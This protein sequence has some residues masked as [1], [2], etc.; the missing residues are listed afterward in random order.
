MKR[1]IA[2]A[3][4]FVLMLATVA[5][6]ADFSAE[7]LSRSGKGKA[8][9]SKL[10]FTKDKMRTEAMGNI[11]IVRM[12]KNVMWNIMTGQKAYMEMKIPAQS[13]ASMSNKAPGEIKREKLGRETINGFR[14]D[15]YKVTYKDPEGRKTSSMYQWLSGDNIPIKSA[16]LDGSWSS[17][18]KNMKKGAQPGSLFEIPAG[19]K[20]MSIPMGAGMGNMKMMPKNLQKMMR[21]GQ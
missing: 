8:I 11:T 19:Y 5:A 4:L 16:A 13:R 15:K 3:A 7:M 12:D 6:A 14:C 9:A 18:I 10:F 17:E 1:S 21:D 20:K 2:I